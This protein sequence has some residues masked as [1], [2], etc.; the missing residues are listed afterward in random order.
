MAAEKK[1]E[2]AGAACEPH[3]DCTGAAEFHSRFTLKFVW[4]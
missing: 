1:K 4:L 3:V 2:P